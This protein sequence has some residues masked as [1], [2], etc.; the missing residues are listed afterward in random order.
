MPSAL[1]LLI[2]AMALGG[3]ARA[4]AADAAEDLIFRARHAQQVE[5]DMERAAALYKKALEDRA[6]GAALQAEVRLRLSGC[7]KEMQQYEKALAQLANH[8]YA[9]E[10]VPER[11]R[12]RAKEEVRVLKTL[13]P[14][15]T[16]APPQH[17][18]DPA[19]QT[20]RE[21]KEVLSAARRLMDRGNNVRALQKVKFALRLAP[22]DE[23]ALAL[24]AELETRFGE[25]AAFVRDAIGILKSWTEASTKL[26]VSDA[27]QLMRK[28]LQ[29]ARKD[30]FALAEQRYR[31]AVSVIDAC[32]FSRESNELVEL[33]RRIEI[34]WRELRR[35]HL[36]PMDADPKIKPAARRST[37]R[38]EF[39]NHLQKMLDEVS[40]GGRE[41]RILAIRGPRAPGRP[42]PFSKPAGYLLNREIPSQWSPANFARHVV[43]ARVAPESW[44]RP[45]NFL[46][47]AGSMLIARNESAVLDAV[48]KE[49]ARLD[50]PAGRRV[51]VRLMLVSLPRAALDTM[52]LH[53]GDYKSTGAAKD[54][55]LYQTISLP[56]DSGPDWIENYFKGLGGEDGAKLIK[57]RGELRNGLRQTLFINEPIRKAA[58]YADAQRIAPNALGSHASQ[59]FG[60]LLDTYVVR[61]R[62]G[63]TAVGLKIVSRIPRLPTRVTSKRGARE[64]TTLHP[65]FVSQTG[66]LFVDLAPGTVLVVP[67]LI[68]PFAAA[69]NK[70]DPDRT[71]LLV[72]ETP[73]RASGTATNTSGQPEPNATEDNEVQMPLGDLLVQVRDDP[74]P[75]GGPNRGF[76]ARSAV[77]IERGRAEFLQSL[78]RSELGPDIRVD[79]TEA[80]L[81][82][83]NAS[84][85]R[86]MR[87]LARLAAESRRTYM[88]R[89]RARSARTRVLE[90]WMVDDRLDWIPFS[91]S[92]V[93]AVTAVERGEVLLRDLGA[94]G[95]D[96][97]AP[98]HDLGTFHVRGLQ[99]RHA[100]S[101]RITTA[102]MLD[103]DDGAAAKTGLIT[104]G[105]RV[106]VRPYAIDRKLRMW[107]EIETAA[108]ARRAD[109]SGEHEDPANRKLETKGAR[110]AGFV[111]IGE[112]RAEHAVIIARIPH[113]TATR[114]ER[115]TEIVVTIT[116]KPG[117]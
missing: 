74:G 94:E 73:G 82:V 77:E 28:G 84:K 1:R 112:S 106:T 116:I 27:T 71:F 34:R 69:R 16:A 75:A 23:E 20:Q 109:P 6:L 13:V 37:L 55:L 100:L 52:R 83:P 41:Y 107:I 12:E 21:V 33:R 7:L 95:G 114:Q 31:K 108:V 102:P 26:V 45:G 48:Q 99:A 105:L 87:A 54:A 50:R 98:D 53:F 67:D 111:D 76:V 17:R 5:G 90:R 92:A 2:L 47:A 38:A 65:R 58:G 81:T 46:D 39:L 22:K 24:N 68:D 85:E 18:E 49:L 35:R 64:I 3:A 29:H 10:E 89:I 103:P 51:P 63:R 78:L 115:I 43:K 104:E 60:L 56:K 44:D 36:G 88:V 11:L 66:E 80:S 14:R 15:A 4:A 113:P 93:V 62:D 61:H 9:H 59:R 97:F 32:E 91:E 25:T 96:I 70:S 40:A 42:P 86:A 72:W 8:I 19:A 110:L 101:G 30:E 117:Q 57:F 79:A